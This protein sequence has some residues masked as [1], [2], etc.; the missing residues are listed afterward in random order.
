MN[1]TTHVPVTPAQT[2]SLATIVQAVFD[3]YKRHRASGEQ[4]LRALGHPDVTDEQ[5]I[6]MARSYG[7]GRRGL[8]EAKKQLMGSTRVTRSWA[9]RTIVERMTF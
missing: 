6:T 7:A 2:R 5:I 1:E 8:I 9:L 4:L 3:L